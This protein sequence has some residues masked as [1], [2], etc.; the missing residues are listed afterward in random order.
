MN[1]LGTSPCLFFDA[2]VPKQES[3][4]WISGLSPSPTNEFGFTDLE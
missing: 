3:K 4:Q 1:E 2:S